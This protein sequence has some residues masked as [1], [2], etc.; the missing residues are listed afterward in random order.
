MGRMIRGLLAGSFLEVFVAIPVHVWA[1]RERE[2]YCCRRTYTT[3]VFAGTV[4][5]WAFGPGL[6]LLY[7]REKYRWEKLLTRAESGIADFEERRS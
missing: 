4:L 7:W 6:V 1:T 3:L 5:L 2:C